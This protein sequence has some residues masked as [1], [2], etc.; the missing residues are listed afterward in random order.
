[1]YDDETEDERP[2]WERAKEAGATALKSGMRTVE[3]GLRL[4]DPEIPTTDPPG[5]PLTLYS[6]EDKAAAARHPIAGAIGQGVVM[7]PLMLSP[8][9]AVAGVLGEAVAG[10]YAAEAEQAWQQDR[11]FSQEAAFQNVGAGLLIGAAASA[12]AKAAAPVVRK[13]GRNLFTE[14]EHAAHGRA[15]RDLMGDPAVVSGDSAAE[16]ARRGPDDEGVR[17]LRDNHESLMDDL[18]AEHSKATQQL[19]D[20]YGKLAPLRQTPKQV[21]G[22]IPDN[23]VEQARWVKDAEKEIGA[24]LDELDPQQAA[25]LRERLATLADGDKPEEWFV[26]ASELSDELTKAQAKAESVIAEPLTVREKKVVGM[27]GN[28]GDRTPKMTPEIETTLNKIRREQPGTLY[29]G[30]KLRPE[31]LAELQ[32]SGRMT[33]RGYSSAT[34]EATYAEGYADVPGNGVVVEIEGLPHAFEKSDREM[35]IP[36]GE[37]DIV[38]LEPRSWDDPHRRMSF[39]GHTLRLRPRGAP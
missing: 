1:M 20:A 37:Y 9:G 38:G 21:R 24:A 6:D 13:L 27:L 5:V 4:L 28:L 32:E 26:R 18:A 39:E 10:G 35:L 19:H 8:G 31:A 33:F 30:M 11:D 7:A 14:A 3:S 23:R 2:L 17:Y 15:A 12:V 22:L 25:P 29:K 34:K 36:P 16:I